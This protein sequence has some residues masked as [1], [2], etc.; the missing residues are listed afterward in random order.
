[1][2]RISK[3]SAVAACLLLFAVMAMGSGSSS[4]SSSSAKVGEAGQDTTTEQGTAAEQDSATEEAEVKTEYHVGDILKDGDVQSVYAASGEYQEENEYMKPEEG[5]KCIFLKL[6]FENQGTSDQSISSLN[7]ECYADG[8]NADTHYT[9]NDFSATLSP[10][11]TTEGMLVFEVPQDAQNIEVEYETN[12]ITEEKLKFIYDGDKDSGYVAKADTGASENA[13]AVGDIV[14]SQN[15]NITYLSCENDT[16]YSEFSEPAAGMHYVT[17]TFEFENKGDSDEMVS[18]YDFDCYAD[19]KNCEQAY[20][21]DD[22][23][24][25]TLSA[26]RKAQGTVTFTVPDDASTVEAEFVSNIWTSDRVVFTVS[27]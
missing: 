26:G 16:S 9:E 3:I 25:A 2:K 12:F 5:K 27:E 22:N 14:E 6:A 1:M 18:M 17:L 15:L 19:G 4:D 23:L 8:Y 20:F 7:F 10:G 11:R 24:T 21:R 13:Y